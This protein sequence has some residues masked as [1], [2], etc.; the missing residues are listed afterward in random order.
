M[1]GKNK[2]DKSALPKG[3]NLGTVVSSAS[4]ASA[5]AARMDWTG[6]LDAALEVPAAD[7]KR[8]IAALKVANPGSSNQQLVKILAKRY[9][10]WAG[11]SSAAVG[12]GAV[13]PGVGTVAA[14]GLT[15]AEL[16]TFL[17]ETAY[18]VLGLAELSGV[19][20]QGKEARRT[21]VMSSLMGDEGAK[22][23]ADQMGISGLNWARKTLLSASNPAMKSINARLV[24]ALGKKLGKRW[25]GRSLGRFIPF[26]VGAALG[27]MSGRSLANNV[28]EGAESA[29]AP[30]QEP[31]QVDSEILGEQR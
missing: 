11:T 10:N 26:G 3:A 20:V 8:R 17:T 22:L 16:L 6:V 18:Y 31:I 4:K 24:K 23:V 28:I 30:F 5:S 27:W 12:A 29:L 15:G 7:I 21:L 2:V 9:R 13:F 1:L 19:P 14:V 25:A